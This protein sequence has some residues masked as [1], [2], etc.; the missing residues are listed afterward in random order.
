MKEII[1]IVLIFNALFTMFFSACIKPK[2]KEVVTGVKIYKLDSG[3]KNIFDKF[4]YLGINTIFCSPQIDSLKDFISLAKKRN[5][6]VFLIV[7]VFYNPE[8]LKKDTSLYAVTNRGRIA[9]DDWV[10]FICPENEEYLKNRIKYIIDLIRI[11]N[12]DGISLDFIR[13]FVYWEMVMPETKPEDIERGCFCKKC[14]NGFKDFSRIKIPEDLSTT[15][16][17]ADWILHNHKKEWGVWE[18]EQIYRS[19]E[20]ITKQIK[21][22]NPKILINLHIVPWRKTDYGNGI[23]NIAGQNLK[24][25]SQLADYISPMCYNHMLKRKPEWICSVVRDIS[26]RSYKPVIPSLQV[27][28]EYLET[29]VSDEEFRDSVNNGL[30]PPSSGIVIWNWE[31]LMSCPGKIDIVRNAFTKVRKF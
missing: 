28:K 10:E 20:K 9:K 22:V 18:S 4:D 27:E 13:Q 26:R 11:Y 23:E 3:L 17:I 31:T 8:A 14:I 5:K 30:K 2:K 15:T 16:E 25:M 7:T 21:A 19:L 6:R 29:K 24:R 12:P 1:K